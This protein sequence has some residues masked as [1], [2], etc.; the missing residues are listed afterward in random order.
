M[1]PEM[2]RSVDDDSRRAREVP[3]PLL[4]LFVDGQS[5]TRAEVIAESGLARS[6]VGP[7]LEALVREG[8][9][10]ER[11]EAVSTG[12]R[13]PTML[14]LNPEY[15][16][17]AVVEIEAGH[18]RVAISDLARRT[19]AEER[20]DEPLAADPEQAFEHIERM[21]LQLEARPG[22]PP[23][24]GI[25]VSLT[26]PVDPR[27]GRPLHPPRSPRWH[28]Y[29]IAGRLQQVL[30]LPVHV[31]A[32]NTL[33]AMGELALDGQG[34]RDMLYVHASTWIGAGVVVDGRVVRG[35]TGQIGHIGHVRGAWLEDDECT[36]GK[37]GCVEAVAGGVALVRRFGDRLRSQSIT[38]VIEAAKDGD[39]EIL[40]ALRDSGRKIGSVIAG[41]ISVLNPA[42]VVLG[43]DLADA[44]AEFLTGVR[45]G[46]NREAFPMSTDELIVRTSHAGD[47][48]AVLGTALLAV[49][50]F[51]EPEDGGE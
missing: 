47:A 44:G 5:R 12:G 6:T 18:L 33:M 42:T 8:A 10:L 9:L 14:S 13:R 4:R 40:G 48:A 20:I 51:V 37:R 22:L 46:I 16:A 19:L 17:V 43:G 15:A 31:D 32:M 25:G 11:G 45:E 39:E 41:Y 1:Q 2:P 7:R 35:A 21:L 34:S 38:A 27:S 23:I 29:D 36:C 28:D 24:V 30:P 50:H 26:A 3:D 49:H